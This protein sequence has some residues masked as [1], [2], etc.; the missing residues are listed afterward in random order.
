MGER[1]QNWIAAN[2]RECVAF[3][4]GI[5]VGGVFSIMGEYMAK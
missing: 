5:I 1:I 2:S 4:L 3:F